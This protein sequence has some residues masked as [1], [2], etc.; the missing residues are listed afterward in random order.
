MLARNSKK[1][2]QTNNFSLPPTK[3]RNVS[4]V[5]CKHQFFLREF[6]PLR[7]VIPLL[8]QCGHV[9]CD[10]CAT[11]FLDRPCPLCNIISQSEDDQTV[12]L[13]LHIYALGLM[14]VSH[15]RPIDIDDLDISFAKSVNSGIKQH[16]M[17]GFCYECENQATIQCPQCN[18]LFCHICYA[19]IH[20]RALQNHSKIMLAESDNENSFIVRNICSEMCNEPLGYYCEDCDIAACSHCMLDLHKKHNYQPLVKKNQELLV[21]LYQMLDYVYENLQRVQQAQKKLK[22]S[23][24]N[25]VDLPE[26]DSVQ[27]SIT[28]HFAYLHG[29]LQNLEKSIIDSLREYQSSRDKN[30]EEISAQLREHEE[31]LQSALI[32]STSITE[33]LEKIDVQQVISKLRTL[34]DIPCHLVLNSVLNEQE[35][36]FSFDDNIVDIVKNHC[37]IR[38]PPVSSYSLR[39]TDSLP[40]DYE[41]EPLTKE[42]NSL[43]HRNTSTT[44]STSLVNVSSKESDNLPQAGSSEMVRVSHVVDPFC[45]Y[46]QLVQNQH[47]LLELNKELATLISASTIPTEIVL[48]TLYIVQSKTGTWYR[49][50]VTERKSHSKCGETYSVT[51]IDY[52]MK[53]EDVPLQRIR[54]ILPQ[55]AIFPALALRCSL[56]DIIPNNGKWHPD[57]IEA[58]KNLV[59][60]NTM[61]SM[62]ITTIT[63][64]IYY[65]D[66]CVVSSK[67]SGLIFV[68]DSLTYMSYATCISSNKLMR[69]NPESVMKYY[70]EQLDMETYTDIRVLFVE[71]PSS[72]F[73]EK[74]HANRS[75]FTKLIQ[76]MNEDYERNTFNEYISTPC[77]DMPCAARGADGLWHR[78]LINEVTEN[79]LQVFYV[80]LGYTLILDYNAV[81]V[82]HRKYMSCKTQAIKVAL[83]NIT[84]QSGDT[85]QWEPETTEFIKAFLLSTRNFKIIAFDKLENVYSIVMY[86]HDKINVGNLLINNGLA[87]CSG[88]NFQ[89]PR[90]RNRSKNRRH[91][92]RLNKQ[93]PSEPY[94]E[95]MNLSTKDKKVDDNDDPFKVSVLIHQVFSP[96]CIYVSDATY[97]QSDVNRLRKEMQQFYNKYRAA[98]QDV[99]CKNAVCAVYQEENNTYHRARIID[100]KSNDKVAVFLYDLGN[101]EIV[102]VENIQSLHPM[103]YK[104]PAYVFKIKLSGILPCGGSNTWP[105][106]SCQKLME[107]MDKNQCSK[108]YISKL[109]DEDVESSVIPVELWVRQTITDG[110]LEPT[111]YE[112]NSVNRMMVENGV[113]LPIK[114]YVKKRDKILAIELKR[115]LMKKLRRLTKCKSNVKWFAIGNEHKVEGSIIE[116]TLELSE[117]SSPNSDYEDHDT[118]QRFDNTPTLPKLTAWLPAKPVEEDTFIAIPT[119]LN[120]DGFVYLH[121]KTENS[122]I[123]RYIEMKLENIY[124]NCPIEPCDTV[125][126]AGD[127]CIAQYHVNNKWYRGKIVSVEEHDI[128]NVEFVDYGNVEE[129]SI[130]TLKKKVVLE[131]IPIQC[132]KCLIHNLKSGTENGKWTT[133]DLDKIHALIIEHE[134][135]VTILERMNTHL[136]ISLTMLPNKYCDKERDLL[137]FLIKNYKMN[138]EANISE[139]Y[140][141][142]SSTPTYPDYTD[143]LIESLRLN[144]SNDEITEDPI[145]SGNSE[146]L[147]HTDVVEKNESGTITDVENLSWAKVKERIIASTPCVASDEDIAMNYNTL[148]IPDDV[149]YIEVELIIG[150]RFTEFQAQLKENIHSPVLNE[151]YTQYEQLMTEL[152][153]NACKQP[154]ITTLAVNTPCCAKFAHD[155]IWYRCL[156]TESKPIIDSDSVKIKLLYIDYGNDEY[157]E[158]DS[159]TYELYTLKKEWTEVP[160]MAIRCKLWNI[161]VSPTADSDTLV[162]QLNELLNKRIIAT[163]K[164]T[165]ENFIYVELRENEKCENVIYKSLIDEGLF[166]IMQEE[167]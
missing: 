12:S 155:G 103:F 93:L 69:V 112:V 37:S 14:I 81:R 73:V 16:S 142:Q 107:I 161:K 134:C 113:A 91:K 43:E 122:K 87:L 3:L 141:S 117:N 35:I 34:V 139:S 133:E 57:A 137:E 18:V 116:E 131:D 63:G 98:K 47:K 163:I 60:K 89:Q 138:I 84:P 108:Y 94:D 51:F 164:D 157:R 24:L 162:S 23:A 85:N 76:N 115:Q 101:E 121:S 109:E 151:Y 40:D 17:K 83:R 160:A 77:R 119:Y 80:D 156:I 56:F 150:I 29:A 106:Y 58:F 158:I 154:M 68:K 36:K 72:I 53:E 46:V 96:D 128:V 44:R 145:I 105:S 11:L 55:L 20:G 54:N 104:V 123:L 165:D 8:L 74:R 79:T 118:V 127:L 22:T 65:V 32:V 50:R 124:S 61:V 114:E 90:V 144:Y 26:T 146:L 147:T 28:Q 38:I 143:P 152:Q 136:V 30:I 27:A 71:S 13:P 82:L 42:D 120:H 62:S 66:L 132:T 64:D 92:S 9:I 159:K 59:F 4:C 7:G 149:D 2:N 67:D 39:R 15:N 78:G 95:P 130:G 111:R 25:P 31:Q 6:V 148:D 126:I 70:R 52:G 10:K 41:I 129:C 153:E 166:E 49:A 140:M 125:W 100:V 5:Q 19:K 33:N 86:T 167:N 97:D 135:K 99:W 88:T 1:S 75:Y 45:F 21:E 110:P 48:N 102:S